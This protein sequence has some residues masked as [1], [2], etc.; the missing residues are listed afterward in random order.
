MVGPMILEGGS[1]KHLAIAG[2]LL[3][4][5]LNTYATS[6]NFKP[7]NK[8]NC[9]KLRPGTPATPVNWISKFNLVDTGAFLEVSFL[10]LHG[11]CSGEEKTVLPI[12]D[13]EA[14]TYFGSIDHVSDIEGLIYD[15]VELQ[16]GKAK[17]TFKIDKEVFFA[18]Y[19][20]AVLEYSFSP[21]KI[22]KNVF[23]WNIILKKKANGKIRVNVT[24]A[25]LKK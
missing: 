20:N 24:K 21:D 18:G 9:K 25:R 19:P 12:E 22:G 15:Q 8:I 11:T 4:L 5:C 7:L 3:F 17:V 23:H 14:L 1:M 13:H 2:S 10:T 6:I 16:K